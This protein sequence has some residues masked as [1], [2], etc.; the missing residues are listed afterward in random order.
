MNKLVQITLKADQEKYNLDGDASITVVDANSYYIGRIIAR[1]H[2]WIVFESVDQGGNLGGIVFIKGDQVAKIED[3]TPNL[4]YY[5]ITQI[6][7]PFNLSKM[8]KPVLD[9]D[10]TNLHD[11]LINVADAQPFTTFEVNTGVTYTGLIT[12]LDQNEVRILERN[13]LTLEHYATVIPLADIVCVDTNAI[14][15]LLFTQY[16]K[17]LHQREF[18]NDLDLVEIYFD[19]T[20]DDQYGSFAIGKVLKYDDDNLILESINELG[21]VE[22]IA[23]IARSHVTHITEDSERLNFFN[24][25]VQWQKRNGSFDPDKLERSVKLRDEIKSPAEIIEDWPDDRVVKIS[26]SIYHYPDRLGLIEDRSDSGFDLKI[27]TEYGLGD[28]SDHDYNDL[29]SVD[30]AGSE[31]IKIQQFLDNEG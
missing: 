18:T 1:H 19:Y 6:R 30:L 28:V 23:V 20:F 2:G 31:M 17:Q 5:A 22:S 7:D 8:N 21:Q 3:D 27:I 13:E 15:N 12:Q 4:R 24:F 26:D 10:F 16:L 25:L 11:L 29:I 9:W 14:D